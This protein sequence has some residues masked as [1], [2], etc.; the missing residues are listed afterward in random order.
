M[1]GLELPINVLI[2]IALAVIVLIAIVAFFYPSFF[3]GSQT[4]SLESAKTQ[5]CRSL[6]AIGCTSSVGVGVIK[7][8][9]DMNGV[10]YDTSSAAL[11][12]G[13]TLFELCTNYLQ[14]SGATADA[15]CRALCGC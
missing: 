13:D 11:A 8:D 3:S 7:F 14:I 5:A 10:I 15:D 9:A 1:K 4:V 6:V 12:G 2:I